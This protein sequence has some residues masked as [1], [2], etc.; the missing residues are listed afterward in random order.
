[1]SFIVLAT[2]KGKPRMIMEKIAN[3][4]DKELPKEKTSDLKEAFEALMALVELRQDQLNKSKNNNSK[5]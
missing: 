2:I 4:I 3:F 5:K 1:M